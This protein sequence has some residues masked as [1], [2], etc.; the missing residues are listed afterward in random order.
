MGK[1]F[2]LTIAL[3]M[4]LSVFGQVRTAQSLQKGFKYG[5]SKKAHKKD[6]SHQRTARVETQKLDSIVVD[7]LSKTY[8]VYNASGQNT[9]LFS[10]EWDGEWV[11][12]TRV[13][14]TYDG[15]GNIS[16]ETIY[17]YDGAWVQDAKVVS[18]FSDTFDEEITYKWMGTE[19]VNVKKATYT[20]AN[21][22]LTNST[23][24]YWAD[25]W[26]E[27]SKS[28]YTND[29]NGNEIEDNHYVMDNSQWRNDRHTTTTYNANNDQ[30]SSVIKRWDIQAS[31][32]V[33]DS[34]AVYTYASNGDLSVEVS[35]YWNV[36]E[37]AWVNEQKYNYTYDEDHAESNLFL[38][39]DL[40]GFKH[41]LLTVVLSFADGDDW[42]EDEVTVLYY[43]NAQTT[44]FNDKTI[45]DRYVVYPN[46]A[47]ESVTFKAD[48]VD[49]LN[50]ALYDAQGTLVLNTDAE[51]NETVSLKGLSAGLYF[52]SITGENGKTEKGKLVVR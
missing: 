47:S 12:G 14:Y 18:T 13:D 5:Y 10:Y 30:T 49:K 17:G 7:G 35:S 25:E 27:A 6:V 43:S 28:D 11:E 26:R 4:S 38:P 40:K 24:Y 22:H 2:T 34:K 41:K 46:P 42:F 15:N 44:S 16:S 23:V 45:A 9:Q 19:W 39:L 32:W 51:S 21:N 20:Y 36:E 8:F 37:E 31:E 48:Q 52:Y 50:I 1:T 29:V 33:N 3:L